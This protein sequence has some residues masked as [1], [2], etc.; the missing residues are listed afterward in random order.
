MTNIP[1]EIIICT[2]S[3][4]EIVIPFDEG[5]LK[6]YN[7]NGEILNESEDNRSYRTP[8]LDKSTTYYVQAVCPYSDAQKKSLVTQWTGGNGKE[9]VMFTL[10][11]KH[12][13]L[14]QSID[15]HCEQDE[16]LCHVYFIHGDMEQNMNNPGAWISVFEGEIVGRGL[17]AP[18]NI[19]IEDLHLTEN[20]KYGFYVT[21]EFGGKLFYSNGDHIYE[22][23]YMSISDGKG[24]SWP[25]GPACGLREFNGKLNYVVGERVSS[26]K[27]PIDVTVI[28]PPDPP[29][30]YYSNNSFQVYEGENFQWYRYGKQI[31]NEIE[32]VFYP[33]ESGDYSVAAYTGECLSQVSEEVYYA[34]PAF[35]DDVINLSVFPNPVV[36][37][38]KIDMTDFD[39]EKYR[40]LISDSS[41]L[42][43]RDDFVWGGKISSVNVSDLPSGRYSVV[44]V[45]G[46]FKRSSV[47]LKW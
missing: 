47:F 11:A 45:S 19:D 1:E 22:D 36:S 21:L 17:G 23:S 31:D 9:G 42:L 5:I 13:V 25:F 7:V 20:E 32:S 41:G 35:S 3:E 44:I 24:I 27:Y 4:T 12:D 18:V 10:K 40:L 29:I 38:L 6:W 33:T 28:D 14:L 2:N 16:S 8:V 37:E 46:G 26:I 34:L 30:M 15:I 39:I 43:K